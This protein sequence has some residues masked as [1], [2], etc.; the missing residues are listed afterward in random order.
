MLNPSFRF[1]L[2]LFMAQ[3]NIVAD[4]ESGVRQDVELSQHVAGSNIKN[5][6]EDNEIFTGKEFIHAI[7]DSE[8]APAVLPSDPGHPRYEL[9]YNSWL[10]A[11]MGGFLAI[12][13][14]SSS[15]TAVPQSGSNM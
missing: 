13:C 6:D 10:L 7:E 5:G 14:V 2:S 11:V 3:V 9:M 12:I 4:V 1:A 8:R 15:R